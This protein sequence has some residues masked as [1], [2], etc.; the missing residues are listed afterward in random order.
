[1]DTPANRAAMPN[2]DFTKWVQP[3]Q[4]AE[5]LV[6]LASDG[7]SNITGAAVPIYGVEP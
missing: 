1:M 6:Y 5:L 7:A 4:A 2:A 3:C